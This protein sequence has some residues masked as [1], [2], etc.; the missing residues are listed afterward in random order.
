MFSELRLGIARSMKLLDEN[1][2]HCWEVLV[3]TCE[4]KLEL[5]CDRKK[6][7]FVF[8]RFYSE[9]S[10]KL[11][12]TKTFVA[13]TMAHDC[14]KR[15]EWERRKPLRPCRHGRED[16]NDGTVGRTYERSGDSDGSGSQRKRLR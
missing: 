7:T 10:Q 3:T 12:R 5:F 9:A 13:V 4:E 14:D 15:R 6:T 11:L 8:V 16:E 1:N 2:F